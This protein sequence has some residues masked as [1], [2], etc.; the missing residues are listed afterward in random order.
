MFAN[1]SASP[2]E[3]G[4]GADSHAVF[5][6]FLPRRP[7]VVA[8]IT[9]TQRV[10]A[11]F[12]TATAPPRLLLQ[13]GR[14]RAPATTRARQHQVRGRSVRLRR[15]RPIRFPSASDQIVGQKR[16]QVQTAFALPNRRLEIPVEEDGGQDECQKQDQ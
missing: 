13:T 7:F 6:T 8:K 14:L 2:H 16:G 9:R 5:L 10:K 11:A 3:N 15:L 4:R 1:N 12:P